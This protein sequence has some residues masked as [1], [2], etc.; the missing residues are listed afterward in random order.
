MFGI[1]HTELFIVLG[2]ALLLFGSRIPS[3]ARSLGKSITEF[4]KG[5]QGIED[6]PDDPA[7]QSESSKTG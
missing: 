7:R 6:K 1:S 4:K 2:I 3:V 5:T